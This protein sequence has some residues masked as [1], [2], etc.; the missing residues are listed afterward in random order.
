MECED[1]LNVE[2]SEST[3]SEKMKPKSQVK[4]ART[5][6]IVGLTSVI[7]AVLKLVAFVMT[8]SVVVL[9]SMLDSLSD[10]VVSMAN[11]MIHTASRKSPD[12]EHPFGHGGIEVLSSLI[13]GVL[14]FGFGVL[15]LGE[16]LQ[17]LVFYKASERL[18][19][20]ELP[21]GIAVMVFAALSGYLIQ[22]YLNRARRG[23][24]DGG[25]RSLSLNADSAH[26]ESD[27]HMNLVT[28]VGLAIVW[29]SGKPYYDSIFGGVG[30]LFLFR[31]GWPIL[32]QSVRE[33]LHAEAD[34]VQQKA[35][36]EIIL[37]A[38]ERVLGV[39]RLRVRTLGHA[40]FVDFHMMLPHKLSLEEA[41]EIGDK[42]TGRI[43]SNYPGADVIFHLDPDTEPV[44]DHRW[45]KRSLIR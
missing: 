17:R 28:G 6:T 18:N 16:S 41:H 38:D 23:F 27:A 37:G 2:T 40:L 3:P 11:G 33:I 45:I 4:V 35:V 36:I 8:G 5:L 43:R 19:P 30:A 31:A 25:E 14:L 39:H 22:L 20:E 15:V 34:P 12:R 9:S 1:A 26:Y 32:K 21:I 24:E 7:L 13:Q 42:V 29:Y 10:A 44:D